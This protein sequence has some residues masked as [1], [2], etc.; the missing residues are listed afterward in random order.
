M[1]DYAADIKKS[2]IELFSSLPEGLT[3]AQ[4]H[5]VAL[6]AAYFLKNEQLLNDIRAEAKLYLEEKDANAC[7]ISVVMMALTTTYHYCTYEDGEETGQV[8]DALHLNTLSNPGVSKI[9]FELY[10]LTASVLHKCKPAIEYHTKELLKHGITKTGIKNVTRMAAILR[11]TTEALD[12]E[13]VRSYEFI[14]RQSSM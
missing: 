1:P 13:S 7:K 3:E 11:A 2:V 5:G 14:A 6:T 8:C 9:D 12:I 4:V 10:C